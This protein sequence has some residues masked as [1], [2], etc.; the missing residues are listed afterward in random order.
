MKKYLIA[1]A[2]TTVFAAPALAANAPDYQHA[3]YGDG[4]GW[5]ALNATGQTFCRFGTLNHQNFGVGGGTVTT[6][7]FGGAANADGT[8]TLDIQDPNND[9]IKATGAQYGMDNVVCNTPFTVTAQSDNGGLKSA[10]TTSD[11]DFAQLI[12]YTVSFGFDGIEGAVAA[13]HGSSTTPTTVMTSNEAHAG[14]AQLNVYVGARNQ[15]VLQGAYSDRL[16][17]TMTPNLGS[18]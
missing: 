6:D 7:G 10:A 9:T 11:P 1:L 13:G 17:L 12:P 8:F 15:L 4:T 18:S 2:A 14:A 3:T 16:V 5:Y